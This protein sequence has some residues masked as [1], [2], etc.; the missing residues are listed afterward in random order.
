MKPKYFGI[1]DAP[2]IGAG[3]G[4][5][6]NGERIDVAEEI[7]SRYGQMCGARRVILRNVV[8]M[9]KTAE[10]LFDNKG[11][12]TGSRTRRGHAASLRP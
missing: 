8:G 5:M 7:S 2:L 11:L 1:A 12:Q 3:G 4:T 6:T 9:T 10:S